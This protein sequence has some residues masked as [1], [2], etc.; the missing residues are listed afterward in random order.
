MSVQDSEGYYAALNVSPTASQ[1]EIHIAYKLLRQAFDAGEEL[2]DAEKV[3]C[4]YKLLGNPSTRAEYDARNEK[5]TWFLDR[6]GGQSRKQ[7]A[8]A[9]PVVLLLLG[10]AL[11]FSF[12]PELRGMVVSFEAGDS[13]YWKETSK[14]IGVVVTYE[15]N[16]PFP[17][18]AP[19][20][21]YQVRAASGALIWL[22][23][24]DVHRHGARH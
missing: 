21:A 10:A 17:E 12:A 9:L 16:H 4:A 3:L 7:L 23:A 2:E 6:T 24:E 20:D 14:P 22:A 8:V 18:G 5:K 19:A 15:A 13:L 11:A 1:T